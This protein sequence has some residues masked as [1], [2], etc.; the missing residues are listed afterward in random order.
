[1]KFYAPKT[2]SKGYAYL[3]SVLFVS[4]I[5][6]SVMGTYLMMSL[7]AIESGLS[8]SSASQAL[9]YAQACAEKGMLELQKDSAYPGQE[10]LT[11]AN[12][13]CYI[14]Q[15]AGTG[16]SDRTLCTES[17]YGTGS[18]IRRFEIVIAQLLPFVQVYSWQEVGS[19]TACT[20]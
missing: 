6:V 2:A 9:E 8:F 16:N 15:P 10:T 13:D 14:L 12:G 7:T 20:Y 11:F 5:A 4:A 3:I 19:I 17:D 1:M 18:Y